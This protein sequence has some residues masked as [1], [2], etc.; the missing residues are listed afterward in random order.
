MKTLKHLF[1]FILFSSFTHFAFAQ[2]IQS[3]NWDFGISFNLGASKLSGITT[4]NF[5]TI[6]EGNPAF[7]YEDISDFEAAKSGSLGFFAERK[8]GNYFALGSELLWVQIEGRENLAFF[9]IEETRFHQSFIAIPTYASLLIKKFRIKGAIQPMI[10]VMDSYHSHSIPARSIN[11]P[12]RQYD[13]ELDRFSHGYKFGLEYSLSSH[14]RLKADF[15]TFSLKNGFHT[16]KNV[17]ATLGVN[18]I[19]LKK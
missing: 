16:Q 4:S 12:L 18:Y 3:Q 7:R 13:F 10:F 11:T 1:L 8:I 15:F 5:F 6:I 14:F 17:Q 9:T 19:F 2:N